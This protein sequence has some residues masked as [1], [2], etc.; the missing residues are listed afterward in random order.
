M[1]I[2][3]LKSIAY[4]MTDDSQSLKPAED[5]QSNKRLHA[6]VW[7]QCKGYKCLAYKN[8][9]GKWINFYTDKKITD[10]VSVIM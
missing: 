8:S 2:S 4:R 6:L 5:G 7:V 10:F 3:I 9:R 1:H